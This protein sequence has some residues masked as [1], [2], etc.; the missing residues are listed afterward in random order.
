MKKTVIIIISIVLAL[1][2]LIL[3]VTVGMIGFVSWVFGGVRFSPEA[4]MEAVGIGASEA[5][6]IEGDG[7]YFYYHT[8]AEM[9]SDLDNM[10]DWIYSVTPVRQ[11]G[12]GMW[13]ASPD[14]RSYS[15]YLEGESEW[16]G[17]FVFVEID[18]TFHNFF[19]PA[20]LN[21]EPS[22]L[23]EALSEDYTSVTVRGQTID[24]FKHSY[25][26]TEDEVAFFDIN[27]TTFVIDK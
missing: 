26:V 24:V 27:G 11:N 18:G 25:F 10:T 22:S 8:I 19:L 15:V 17:S 5:E 9:Y 16:I 7:V 20:V 6:R 4:A 1:A 23:S 21:T 13:Y 14:P 12:I 2:V 3:S